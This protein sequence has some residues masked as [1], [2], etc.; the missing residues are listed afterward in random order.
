MATQHGRD[1]LHIIG[2]ERHRGFA[3]GCKRTRV[4]FATESIPPLPDEPPT[5]SYRA[6]SERP[7]Q[8][9][10]D[11]SCITF[12]APGCALCN[13]LRCKHMDP[14]TPSDPTSERD[15]EPDDPDDGA[16]DVGDPFDDRPLTTIYQEAQAS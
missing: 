11:W 12:C 2:E 5:L 3:K 14:T 9:V 16:D 10:N 4:E 7:L 6:M 8:P 15:H 1:L 13:R